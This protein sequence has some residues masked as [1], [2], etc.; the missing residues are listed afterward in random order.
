MDYIIN[1]TQVDSS[2]QHTHDQHEI[3]H[4]TRGEGVVRIKEKE[5]D[6]SAGDILIVPP[7]VGHGAYSVGG[8]ERIYIR[9]AFQQ[10][11]SFDAAVLLRDNRQ[12]EGTQLARLIYANRFGNR[13]YLHTLCT[14]YLQFLL[15]HMEN[16]S[17]MGSAVQE[18]VY[19]LTS[20][21]GDADLDTAEILRQSGYAEDYIRAQFRRITGKTPLEFL[22][23]VRIRHACFLMEFYGETLSLGQV[24]E[25][26]GYND[27]VYFSKKFKRVV[28]LSPRAYQTALITGVFE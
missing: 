19:Q 9:G 20:R 7:G 17:E 14:A 26:C 6:V 24:A 3:I 11:F 4:Y 2:A 25:Q 8:V 16:K 12:G 27:Y 22:T 15:M 1:I 28:G 10:T 18:V 23:D 13:E 21:F 5:F